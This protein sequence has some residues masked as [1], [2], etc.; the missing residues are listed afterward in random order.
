MPDANDLTRV[1]IVEL[2]LSET[3]VVAL[4]KLVRTESSWRDICAGFRPDRISKGVLLARS[5]LIARDWRLV[6]QLLA[7]FLESLGIGYTDLKTG[8]QEAGM[9]KRISD[10]LR[11]VCRSLNPE[12]LADIPLG[13]SGRSADI[14]PRRPRLDSTYGQPPRSESSSSNK[15]LVAPSKTEPRA[16]EHPGSEDSD[17]SSPPADETVEFEWA[18][19]EDDVAEAQQ[20]VTLFERSLVAFVKWGPQQLHGDA[21][22]RRGCGKFVEAWKQKSGG[23]ALE[24][25]T[26][27]GCAELGE[28]KDIIIMKANWPAFESTFGSRLFVEQ[29]LDE[30]IPLR[31]GGMHPGER[32]LYLSE[33]LSAL[34]AMVKIVAVYHPDTASRI[35]ELLWERVGTESGTDGEEAFSG[36]SAV[37]TNLA[38]C[39]DP[40]IVGRESEM[41]DL[42]AFWD[43]PYTRVASIVGSGG[44]GKTA[45]LDSFVSR[46]LRSDL[47]IEGKPDPELLIYLTAKDNYLEGTSPA[48]RSMQ[49]QTLRRI[50]EVT[51][52]AITGEAPAGDDMTKHRED[53]LSL[54]KDL[55]IFLALDN[56][57]SLT[58]EDLEEVG[59]LL[60]DL[61]IPSKA[62]VTTRDN[63]RIGHVI[64]LSGLPI[65]DGREMILRALSVSSIEVDESQY[66][67]IDEIVKLTSGVPLYLKHAANLMANGC[68]AAEALQRLQG[69]SIL[70]FLEFSYATSF[71]TLS[72]AAVRVSYCLA[73]S[74]RPRRRNELERVC[75]EPDELD[76]SLTRLNQLAFIERGVDARKRVTFRLSSLQLREYVLERA[77][78]SLSNRV[79][80]LVA[81]QVG[82]TSLSPT[83][84]VDIAVRSVIDDA[85]RLW[86]TN[87]RDGIRALEEAKEE[88]DDHPA[89]LARLGYFY[90]KDGQRTAARQHMERAIDGG[91]EEP[92]TFATLA[93]LHYL[94]GQFDAAIQRSQ[95]ATALRPNYH[96]AEQILGQALYGKASTSRLMMSSDRW[97]QM[98]EEARSRLLRS[99]IEDDTQGW[100]QI[101][102]DRSHRF[103]GRIEHEMLRGQAARIS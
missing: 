20:A 48:P 60:D 101:H 27:L 94:G 69:R 79:A 68:S 23:T 44:V 77:P 66:A 37:Q 8:L 43:D 92:E 15:P 42:H 18:Q 39:E 57:E 10:R 98:M 45:L 67:R 88:W 72:E 61:P 99:I 91:H 11:R 49:F 56:L 65:E 22:L 102:N 58:D 55:R 26:L 97:Q 36:G 93:L 28:L 12:E 19:P 80:V 29:N 103:V 87:W 52:E 47:A 5:F 82:V 71:S 1:N 84:N 63:R 76:E 6:G 81:N 83:K 21:W 40:R 16:E 51:I 64:T 14:S 35:D 3:S 4:R 50:D 90:F 73:L 54:A 96:W 78:K 62:V 70:S 32:G 30:I 86:R 95:T 31:V 17:P 75:E 38:H 100:Q 89:I 13:E 53:V 34:A 41:R 85:W 7:V 2:V 9:D 59:T 24:P 33:N 25:D 74:R 46:R